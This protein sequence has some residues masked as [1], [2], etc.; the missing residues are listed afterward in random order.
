MAFNTLYTDTTLIALSGTDPKAL[1]WRG[2]VGAL[3]IIVTG[4]INFDLQ[5]TNADLNAGETAQ[6]LVDS[7]GNA[8]ITASKWI[9]FNGNP[10]FIRIYV[11]SLSAGATVRLLYTQANGQ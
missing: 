4:T 2:G 10:R 8:G 6:W 1:N 3:E 9:T 5:S 11:N 7:S